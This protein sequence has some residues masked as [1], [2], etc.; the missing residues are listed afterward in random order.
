[1]ASPAI[2]K[3]QAEFALSLLRQAAKPGQDAFLSPLSISLALAMTYTGAAGD[4]AKQMKAVMAPGC[5]IRFSIFPTH[6]LGTGMSDDEFHKSFSGIMKMV[7]EPSSL[8]EL[9]T[10]NRVYAYDKMTLKGAA[11]DKLAKHYN[12]EMHLVHLVIVFCIQ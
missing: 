4:T 12:T 2:A 11:K 1:M 6:S 7:M 9:H 5:F 10:A 8:H 3:A